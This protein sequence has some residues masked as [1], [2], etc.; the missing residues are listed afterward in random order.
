MLERV[1]GCD[2][3]ASHHM[4]ERVSGCASKRQLRTSNNRVNPVERGITIVAARCACRLR[5]VPFDR[6]HLLQGAG[7]HTANGENA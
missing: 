5:F 4:L 3:D 2:D 1:S 6:L 7:T